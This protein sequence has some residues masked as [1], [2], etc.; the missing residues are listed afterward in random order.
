MSG[1]KVDLLQHLEE[2]REKFSGDFIGIP[3]FHKVMNNWTKILGSASD[4]KELPYVS[5]TPFSNEGTE[6]TYVHSIAFPNGREFEFE[7]DIVRAIEWFKKRSVRKVNIE[8]EEILPYMKQNVVNFN[9]PS[10]KTPQHP[11]IVIETC[12]YKQEKVIINGNHRIVEAAK[13]GQKTV[14]GY[15]LK[16]HRHREWMLS[17]GMRLYYEFLMDWRQLEE[18]LSQIEQ[19]AELDHEDFYRQ[20]NIARK[21]Q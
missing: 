4:I 20:L 9:D 10:L 11:I 2:V 16:T 18:A 19:G 7:W 17:E 3:S 5:S 1:L 13:E 15:H 14:T 8:I 21:N 6:E 12:L